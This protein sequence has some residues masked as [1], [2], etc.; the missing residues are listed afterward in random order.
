MRPSIYRVSISKSSFTGLSL[1]V[2]TYTPFSITDT[3]LCILA[4]C[5]VA[6]VLLSCFARPPFCCVPAFPVFGNGAFRY[7]QVDYSSCS[8]A[9]SLVFEGVNY[10]L[11]QLHVHS[12]SEHRVSCKPAWP[13]GNITAALSFFLKRKYR[14]TKPTQNVVPEQCFLLCCI[15]LNTAG[16]HAT[17]ALI[18]HVPSTSGNVEVSLLR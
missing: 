11:L 5:N 10:N 1:V 4:Q 15:E 2:H 12:V 6:L 8:E 7:Q 3:S 14:V 16:A 17:N 13:A 18:F 9:P